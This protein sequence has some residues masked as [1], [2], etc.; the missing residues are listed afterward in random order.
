[1]IHTPVMVAE[2]LRYLLHDNSRWVVDCTVGGGG[3]AKAVLDS[4]SEVS[5]VGID[6]D[7]EAL[8]GARR[9]LQE[10]E[11]RLSLIEGNYADLDAA[12]ADRK[13]VDGILVDLGVSSLQLD[14]AS[15]GFGY[16]QDGP[17]DMRMGATG[18]TAKSLIENST[19]EQ[20]ARILREYGEVRG[21]ARIARSIRQAADSG[22]MASTFDLRRAIEAALVGKPSPGLLSKVF[23]GIRIALNRELA[24]LEV[25]LDRVLDHLHANGRLVIVSYHSLEDR[26]VKRFFKRESSDCLCP[27]RVPQCVCG[28]KATLELL[29]PRVLKPSAEEIAGNPRSRS[30]RLRA[31]KFLG[32]GVRSLT[33]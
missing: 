30:A 26:I 12:L 21:A 33:N 11:G 3:H 23:Q 24:N 28:H 10:Y 2:T 29:T 32:Q 4:N 6:R 9:F 17:L 22:G 5:L 15:R 20:L 31:A 18:Q 13:A 8:A 19:V 27:P 16:K 14:R 7:P 25:F 1:M